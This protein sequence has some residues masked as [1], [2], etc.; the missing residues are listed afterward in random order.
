LYVDLHRAQVILL[1]ELEQLIVEAKEHAAEIERLIHQLTPGQ[2]LWRPR[3]NKWC[4]GEH[5]DHLA[6]T[7]TRYARAIRVALHNARKHGLTGSGPFRRSLF[8]TWFVRS[9]EPPVRI[10]IKTFPILTPER[11]TPPDQLSAGFKTAQDAFALAVREAEGIDLGKA[12]M[13]SP[14]VKVLKLTVG[15]ALEAV[16]AHNRRHLWHI[17][18]IL[19]DHRFKSLVPSQESASPASEP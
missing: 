4:I 14:F 19:N 13:R 11:Q 9:L 5:I 12:T 1:N 3:A 16:L 15:E 18:R 10:R 2:L 6:L 17:R 7:T 8:G